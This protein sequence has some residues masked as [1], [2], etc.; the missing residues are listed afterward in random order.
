MFPLIPFRSSLET[1]QGTVGPLLASGGLTPSR[2]GW[3]NQAPQTWSY[4]GRE[5]YTLSSRAAS[6]RG[7]H[8]IG[9]VGSGPADSGPVASTGLHPVPSHGDNAQQ[10]VPGL[11]FPGHQVYHPIPSFS[12]RHVI[13]KV[14]CSDLNEPVLVGKEIRPSPVLGEVSREW[15]N[16]RFFFLYL[17]THI[18]TI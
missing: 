14:Y 17:Y 15:P 7:V 10:R 8:P 3:A 1:P 6:Q 12:R 16:G 4:C 11:S 5:D 2:A 18:N 9:A 13:F